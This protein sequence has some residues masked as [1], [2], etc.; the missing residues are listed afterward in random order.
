[1]LFHLMRVYLLFSLVWFL[2]GHF[3]L[4]IVA[5]SVYHMFSKII[6]TFLLLVISCFG[7]EGWILVLIALIPDLCILFILTRTLY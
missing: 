7:V 6:L 1:M 4:E 5:H 2:S 3:F